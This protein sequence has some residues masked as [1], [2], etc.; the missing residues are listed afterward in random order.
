[1]MPG[2]YAVTA[3]DVDYSFIPADKTKNGRERSRSLR[4]RVK[5]IV[6]DNKPM[7]VEYP[8]KKPFILNH[9][10]LCEII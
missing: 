2:S 4:R 9:I 1:M 7:E 3:M 8:C 6:P 10:S 5:R